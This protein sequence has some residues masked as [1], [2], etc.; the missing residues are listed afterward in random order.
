M[1]LG[2]RLELRQQG[3]DPLDVGR[4]ETGIG[5]KAY[6]RHKL[7]PELLPRVVRDFDGKPL[8]ELGARVR[9][10]AA[11]ARFFDGTLSV[12]SGSG[13]QA[14]VLE[15][16][17]KAT[18]GRVNYKISGE[19]QLQLFDVLYEQPAGS[20]WRGLFERMAA[21]ANRFAA[22][23][24][25][26]E[27][28]SLAAKYLELGKGSYLGDSGRG[29]A[30]ANLFLVFWVGNLMGSRDVDSPDGDHRF[31]KEKIDE[32]PANLLHETRRRNKEYIVWLASHLKG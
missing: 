20:Y 17:G 29:R 1:P 8:A 11:V 9:E 25:F 15:E 32:L 14:E 10:L 30:D 13:K 19:L 7:W 22:A 3:I 16:I 4:P 31:F 6:I 24:A 21:R 28:S 18:G 26:G 5:L 12:H 2:H 23:G 27:E